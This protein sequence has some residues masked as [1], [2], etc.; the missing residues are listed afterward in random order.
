[1]SENEEELRAAVEKKLFARASDLAA[2][3][4]APQEQI[5]HL[6]NEA[7]WQISA[8]FRNAAGTR[9]LAERQG[10]SRIQVE[11]YLR[12]RSEEE[13]SRGGNKI[14][15]PTFDHHTSRYL[16]FDEWLDFLIR[17]WDKLAS[18]S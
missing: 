4:G 2:S 6:R 18:P 13:R 11:D 5:E 17:K 1:M 8:V 9:M 10:L 7:L 15:E 16:T 12:K 14:L 3:V